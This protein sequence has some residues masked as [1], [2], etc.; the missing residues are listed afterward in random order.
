MI[1]RFSTLYVGHIE[2]EGCGLDGVPADD[3]R[4]PNARLIE[5]FDSAAA[6]A[7]AADALGY[8][9]FW[10]AEHHF[11][12]EGWECIPNIPMLAVDLAHRTRR[13]RIGCAFNVVPGLASAA[14]GRGL[15]GRRHPDEGPRGLRRGPWIPQP[16]SRELR[17]PHAGRRGQ[18]RALR[19]AGGGD[20]EGAARGVVLA[21]GQALHDP[22]RG[23]VSRLHAEGDLAGAAPAAPAGGGVAAHRERRGARAR[24]H[25]P[26]R[27]QGRSSPRTAE[28]LVQRWVRDY[29]EAGRRH[30]RERRAR[31]GS[32]PRLPHVPRRHGGGRDPARAAVLRGAR[33]GDGA[34]RHAALQRGARQ[35]G[36]RAAA[37]V[38][39]HRVAGG[40]RAESLVALRPAGGHRRLPEGRWRRSTPGSTT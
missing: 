15:R 18:S 25:G 12:H 1:T 17:Q 31:R 39:H 32:D 14:A 6:V 40:R 38:A 10:L 11:Q 3:R 24:V 5:A 36:G 16:R 4:Y 37:A 20:P 19:G 7:Q 35:G 23:A 27:H 13:V 22:A 2:L 30:G 29:Q 28:E 8:E 26:P 9:T 34:A 21:P 33:Q